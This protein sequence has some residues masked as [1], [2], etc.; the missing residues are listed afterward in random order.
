MTHDNREREMRFSL[1]GWV[2]FVV[3]ALFFIASSLQSRDLLS[4]IGSIIFLA[5][6]FVFLYPLVK[7]NGK[8]QEK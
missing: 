4:L 3:C 7:R 6:C 8:D 5:A 2:L 1:W